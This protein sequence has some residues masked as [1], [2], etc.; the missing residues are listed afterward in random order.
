VD[1]PTTYKQPLKSFPDDDACLDYLV[2]LRWP[3]G[4][5][6][7]A[8]GE[9]GV[10]AHR[11]GL[12]DVPWEWSQNVVDLGG[13][14]FHHTRPPLSMWFAAIWFVTSSRNG[15]SA[16]GLYAASTNTGGRPSSGS[17]DEAER[18]AGAVALSEAIAVLLADA[19]ASTEA[20][21]DP[22]GG[23]DTKPAP[24]PPSRSTPARPQQGR[25]PAALEIGA[26]S[27]AR[28]PASAAR[29]ELGLLGAGRRPLSPGS[30]FC[31][32]AM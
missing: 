32:T 17:P 30:G 5:V 26:A 31:S 27:S 11:P 3:D 1:Y 21:L 22:V 14:I 6:C 19:L 15:I 23:M 4:S 18:E 28:S 25:H 16:L 7:P 24:N 12:R 29:P 10:L 9:V 2:G 8:F 20:R 13:T